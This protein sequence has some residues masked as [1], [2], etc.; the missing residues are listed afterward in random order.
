MSIKEFSEA[1]REWGRFVTLNRRSKGIPH[2]YDIVIGPTANDLTNPTIQF[3][4]SGGVGEVGSDKAI[5][6]FD[7]VLYM[8]IRVANLY[9]NAHGMSVSDFLELD[10]K[11]DFLPFVAD[12]YEPFHLTGDPGILEEIDEFLSVRGK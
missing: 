4:L 2:E 7:H 12:A 6:D 11:T 5:D 8:Q 3:Y 10:R 9:R 1:D